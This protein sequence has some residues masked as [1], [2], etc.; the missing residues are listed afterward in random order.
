MLRV[1]HQ[2]R[3]RE[4][5]LAMKIFRI[6]CLATL[7]CSVAVR[8]NAEIV[9]FHFEGHVETVTAVSVGGGSHPVPPGASQGA[10]VT[11]SYTFDTT[12]RDLNPYSWVGDYVMAA[13]AN[14]LFRITFGGAAP[15]IVDGMRIGVGPGIGVLDTYSIDVAFP[16]D[17]PG[18][19]CGNGYPSPCIGIL[20]RN[21]LDQRTLVDQKLPV[22]PSHLPHFRRDGYYNYTTANG[23]TQVHFIIGRVWRTDLIAVDPNPDLVDS[24]LV[25]DSREPAEQLIRDADLLSSE[26]QAVEVVAADGITPV[27]LRVETEKRLK[28]KITSGDIRSGTLSNVGGA[29]HVTELTPALEE[30]SDGRKFAFAVFT[31]PS[32]YIAALSPVQI[33]AVSDDESV[34]LKTEILVYRPPVVL[35][36]GIWDSPEFFNDLR[37]AI[38]DNGFL[39]ATVSYQDGIHLGEG[40]A[41]SNHGTERLDLVIKDTIANFRAAD[42]A[43]TRVN[44]VAHSMGGLV[45]RLRPQRIDDYFRTDTFGRGDIGKVVTLN[46]PHFGSNMADFLSSHSCAIIRLGL[47]GRPLTRGGVDDLKFEG[48]AVQSLPRDPK[49]KLRIHSVNTKATPGQ[50]RYATQLFAG[51]GVGNSTAGSFISGC[52]SCACRA[53]HDVEDCGVGGQCA[54][55]ACVGSGMTCSTNDDCP[56][57][58]PEQRLCLPVGLLEGRCVYGSGAFCEIGTQCPRA[59]ETCGS[60]L[61]IAHDLLPKLF[62]GASDAVVPLN[63]QTAGQPINSRTTSHVDGLVHSRSYGWTIIDRYDSAD[64]RQSV[65]VSGQVIA[66]VVSLLDGS[67]EAFDEIP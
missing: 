42:W 31:A 8:A 17:S 28:F 26:G 21:Y 11:G 65:G 54:F 16:P 1:R 33:T 19:D 53:G 49:K 50:I 25:S 61:I 52:G 3:F 13:G 55:R 58:Y 48:L 12:A 67:E 62:N 40:F 47:T 51:L 18:T 27:L 36:H 44:V 60:R 5:G 24:S 64:A 29:E 63:S 46:T 37:P 43:I 10:T 59:G 45:T 66:K 34:N 56:S 39:V 9:T 35:I 57:P 20:F 4:K 22:D 6:A 14:L 32:E 15:M 2:R 23:R 7:L 38:E 41:S 30:T